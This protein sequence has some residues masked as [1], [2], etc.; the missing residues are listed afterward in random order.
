M[1]KFLVLLLMPFAMAQAQYPIYTFYPQVITQNIH[2]GAI[3]K[4]DTIAVTIKVNANGS[5]VRSTYFDFQHQF[6]AISLID[7]TMATAGAQGSSLPAGTTTSVQNYFYPNCRLNRTSQNTTTSSWTNYSYANYTCNASTVPN[8]AINRIM[9]NVSSTSNL[10]NGDYM[11]LR[12]KITNTTAGFPYDSIR[13]NFA[14][15]Y[16][17]NGN[18]QTSTLGEPHASWVQL[19]TG[20]NNL[21]T[22]NIVLPSNLTIFPNVVILDSLTNALVTSTQLTSDGNFSFSTELQPRTSYKLYVV[23]NA[24]SLAKLSTQATTVSDYTTAFQEFLSQNLDGTYKNNNLTRGVRF[25]AAD[26]SK[27]GI[28]DGGDVQLLFN[29]IS[30]IDTVLKKP[31]GASASWDYESVYLM[32][33]AIYDT[34]S[35]AKWNN[36]TTS[37]PNHYGF[38]T[39]NVNQTINL[40]YLLLGDPNLSMSSPLSNGYNLRMSNLNAIM[41]NID[42]N[43]TNAVV[44]TNTVTVPFEIDTRGVLLDA[45]QFQIEYDTTKVKFDKLMVDTPNWISFITPTNGILR[46][47]AIDKDMKSP[48]TGKLIPFKLQF[49]TLQAGI[50]INS[51]VTISPIYDA[52]DSKGNQVA[53]NLNTNVVK[54][55]GAN[56]FR[57]P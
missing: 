4:N 19:A 16:Q 31:S 50:D 24:D 38:T 11:Y 35:A 12:F 21:V 1:K 6:T 46:F 47:G 39:T 28:F 20:A 36:T 42:V 30:G 14:A 29:A 17:S 34:I 49:V 15:G 48:I 33:S 52:A 10:G 44:T 32:Q 41:P 23:W 18:Q 55:I 27:N 26:V 9:A 7:V 53:I 43:L 56:N 51:S 8:D 45:V 22:G 40:K 13:M 25:K 3:Q 37:W 54:L 5:T 57:L 2:G